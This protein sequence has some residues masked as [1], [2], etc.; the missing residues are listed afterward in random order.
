MQEEE[1]L[2]TISQSNGNEAILKII[3]ISSHQ[4]GSELE[5]PMFV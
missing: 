2:T 3:S 5:N 4:S 1:R